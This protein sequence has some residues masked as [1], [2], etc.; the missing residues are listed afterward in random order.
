M[1]YIL[2]DFLTNLSGHGPHEIEPT[3]N[4]SAYLRSLHFRAI[5]CHEFECHI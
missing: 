4:N 2:G 5:E 1:G 3:I